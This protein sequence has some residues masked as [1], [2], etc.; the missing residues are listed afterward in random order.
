MSDSLDFGLPTVSGSGSGKQPAF[1][2]AQACKTWLTILPLTKAAQ[3]Q[4]QLLNQLNLLNRYPIPPAERLRILELLR[5]PAHFV[6]EE[7]ARRFVSHPLPLAASEQAAFD[8]SQDLWQGLAIGY[9]HCLRAS[10]EGDTIT[11]NVALAAERALT[12]L[13]AAQIDACRAGLPLGTEYC[14]RLHRIYR[15]AERLK[16]TQQPVDDKMRPHAGVTTAQDAYVEALL[17]EAAYPWELSAKYLAWM[18]RWAQRW[19]AKVSLLADLPAPLA[20]LKTLPL[21]V[22]LGGDQPAKFNVMAADQRIDAPGPKQRWLELTELRRSL[23]KRLAL[24]ERGDTPASIDLGE[25][26]TQPGAETLLKQVYQFWCKGGRRKPV[27]GVRNVAEATGNGTCQLIGGMEAIHAI[28]SGKA[29]RQPGRNPDKPEL[30]R[31]EFEQI[32]TFGRVETHADLDF[33]QQPVF[34]AEEWRVLDESEKA[35][36]MLLGRSYGANGMRLCRHQLVALRPADAR[37]FL[38]GEVRWVAADTK[39][40][41]L[42]A[43]VTIFPGIPEPVALCGNGAKAAA[44]NE[45]YHQGFLLPAVALLQEPPCVVTPSGWFRIG[46][47]LDVYSGNSHQLRLTRLI[48]RGADFERSSFEVV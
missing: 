15:V 14:R 18:Q 5:E 8:V 26:C 29:F 37:G 46:R 25:D 1:V 16:L 45:Q 4:E 48:E 40:N 9:L 30:S 41:T 6:Q 11:L 32:A 43:S 31:R 3:S 19:A 39:R 2:T 17:I 34:A 27:I 36:G 12:T 7:T 38:L 35:A 33:S 44:A 28:I 22:N 21:C 23:K 47:V 13:T 10:I 20:E 42:C 24:L